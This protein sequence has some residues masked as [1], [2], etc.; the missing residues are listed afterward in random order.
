MKPAFSNILWSVLLPLV[1]VTADARSQPP[2]LLK[3]QRE[4]WKASLERQGFIDRSLPPPYRIAVPLMAFGDNGPK[5]MFT[6]APR[7][8]GTGQRQVFLVFVKIPLD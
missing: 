8:P 7:M 5:L 3:M 6:Y 1:F 4:S 2:P